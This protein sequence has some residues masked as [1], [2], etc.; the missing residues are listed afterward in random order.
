[1]DIATVY[2]SRAGLEPG[3]PVFVGRTETLRD[4][5]LRLSSPEMPGIAIVGPR[6]AGKTS[7]LRQLLSSSFRAVDSQL[8]RTGIF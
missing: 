8:I 7:L 4:V 3:S 6:R 5:F 1:M 2:S